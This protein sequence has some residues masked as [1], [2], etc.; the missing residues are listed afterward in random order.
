MHSVAEALQDIGY[1]GYVSAEA[2]PWPDS[3]SAAKQTINA[4]NLYFKK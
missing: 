1:S 3:D 4:F 2:F